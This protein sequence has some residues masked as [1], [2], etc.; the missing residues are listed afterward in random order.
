MYKHFALQET[1]ILG[2]RY[3]T[4]VNVTLRLDIRVFSEG[5][6]RAIHVANHGALLLAK[7]AAAQMGAKC[8]WITRSAQET[9]NR[10]PMRRK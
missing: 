4:V 6:G 7:A 8:H 5:Y 9:E 10:R 2:S 1:S 3:G